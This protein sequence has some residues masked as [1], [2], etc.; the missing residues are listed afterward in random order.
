MAYQIQK[1]NPLD[2]EPNIGIGVKLP[3]NEKS[4]FDI[5]YTSKDAIR[6]NLINFFLTNS[7]E[8]I[9]NLQFGAN[10]RS[11]LFENIDENLLISVKEEI[12][13]KL[14][15]LFSRVNIKQ[16][17]IVFDAN[18]NTLNVLFNYSIIDSNIEDEILINIETNG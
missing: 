12:I 11:L 7:Q 9:F 4:I 17:D 6:T 18:S 14:K 10:L 16:F 3:F 8:R 13:R 2:L 1:I 15:I 5:T